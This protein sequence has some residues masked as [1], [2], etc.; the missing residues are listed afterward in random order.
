LSRAGVFRFSP[1][2]I[3]SWQ[4]ILRCAAR[5]GQAQ[6]MACVVYDRRYNLGFPGAQRLHPFDLRKYA[7]AWK[8]LR[9]EIGPDLDRLHVAVPAPGSDEEL[10]LA[11]TAE[12]L[13]SLRQSAVVAQ[14]IEVPALRRAPW[15][16]LERFVLQPMRWMTAGTI[17][18][19]RAAFQRGLAFNLG[20]G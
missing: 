7:R 6:A 19:G 18:A 15:W 13:K 3:R 8:A 14:A 17:L 20:G 1:R 11:H 12:Y 10:S 16:L 9:T 4:R 5:F 2:G